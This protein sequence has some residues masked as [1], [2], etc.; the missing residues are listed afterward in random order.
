MGTLVTDGFDS[1][2]DEKVI[3]ILKKWKGGPLSDQLFTIIAGMMPTTGVVVVISYNKKDPE[4]VF[5]DRPADDPKW[6]NI[7]NLPGKLFRNA[8]F[9]RTDKLPQNGPLERIEKSEI[10]S[11]FP[12]QPKY[13]GVNLNS[14]SRGSWA[15]LV[16]LV[17][18]DNKDDY[19]SVGEWV[20]V[21]EMNKK[22]NII[23]TEIN[24]INVALGNI[25]YI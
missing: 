19:K 24:H 15:V 14:D 20:R 13:I 7:L 4:V 18:L 10:E 9:K 16:Y 5:V 17:E 23:Q 22:N 2:D 3:S 21:S 1:G 11:E 25:K 12:K 6:P 8:D